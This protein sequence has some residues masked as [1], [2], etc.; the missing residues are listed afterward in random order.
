M[1]GWTGLGWA[2]IKQ[3]VSGPAAPLSSRHSSVFTS[4]QDPLGSL[5]WTQPATVLMRMS[6]DISSGVVWCGVVV[7]TGNNIFISSSGPC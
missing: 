4:H 1:I 5:D 2:E 6:N 3:T 7:V